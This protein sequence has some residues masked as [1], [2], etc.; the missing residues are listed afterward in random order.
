MDTIEEN[1]AVKKLL[2]ENCSDAI[3]RCGTRLADICGEGGK[4]MFCGNGGSAADSQH[5]AAELVIRLRGHVNRPAIT[6][7]ALTVDSSIMTAGGNDIGFENVFAREVEAFGKQG[8]ALVGIS[9]SGNS[10]NVLRAIKQARKQEV[11][12]IGLLG[13]DGGK[14]LK[15]CDYSVVVPSDVTA[16]VQ[17]CHI[18]IGHIWCE[19]IEE[20]LFPEHFIK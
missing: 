3:A 18:L 19:I 20:M 4:V 1:I 7:M 13:C 8:D 14:I 10:E 15:E 6:A 11:I 5:L 2:L 17:E 12:T 16:R 9:T